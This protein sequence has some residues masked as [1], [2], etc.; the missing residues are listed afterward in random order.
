M[1]RPSHVRSAMKTAVASASAQPTPLPR[2][3]RRSYRLFRRTG[4]VAH[5]DVD[6]AHCR[7]LAGLAHR[8]GVSP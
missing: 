2:A 6:H 1:S 7:E 4:H 5:Q 3:S 8:L